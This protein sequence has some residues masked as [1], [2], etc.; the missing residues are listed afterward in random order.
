MLRTLSPLVVAS[1]VVTALPADAQWK[2][3]YGYSF[4]NPISATLNQHVWDGINRRLLLRSMLRKKGTYT[5]A[6]LDK[7]TEA[8]LLAALGGAKQAAAESVKT[9]APAGTGSKFRPARTRL[10]VSDL[11]ASLS[12]DPAA[13]QALTT[14]FETGLTAYEKEAQKDGLVNDLGGAMA[15]FLGSAWMVWHDGQEP[16]ENGVTLVARQLQQLFDTPELQKTP[17]AD[18]QKVSELLICFGTYVDFVFLQARQKKD[19]QGLAQARELA[20]TMLKGFFKLEP[21]QVNITSAGLQIT[22]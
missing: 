13:Q 17:D 20:G 12:K 7:M 9:A 10:A 1:L 5:D 19:P 16:D 6:Q 21:G 8:Q 11:V 22:R 4:N 3:S 14:L 15:F 18:K 2:N